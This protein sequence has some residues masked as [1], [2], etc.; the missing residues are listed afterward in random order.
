MS[1]LQAALNKR[2]ACLESNKP[3]SKRSAVNNTSRAYI[4]RSLKQ[5]G[6]LDRNGKMVNKV[7]S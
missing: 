6:I 2:L 4:E 1:D 5:A 7:A 3:Q